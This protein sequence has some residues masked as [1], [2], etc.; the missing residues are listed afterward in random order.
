MW[1]AFAVYD[2]LRRFGIVKR[3]RRAVGGMARRALAAVRE[4]GVVCRGACKMWLYRWIVNR[5][6]GLATHD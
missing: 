4:S 3:V 1:Y 5:L 6:S 2:A